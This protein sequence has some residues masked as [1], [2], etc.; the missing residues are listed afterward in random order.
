MVKHIQPASDLRFK[1][2]Y[3]EPVRKADALNR[4]LRKQNDSHLASDR[5]GEIRDSRVAIR[6][7]FLRCRIL[8]RMRR[9]LR[10]ILRRPLPDFFVPTRKILYLI[11]RESKCQLAA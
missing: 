10:P 1:L 9:F 3:D 11:I 4:V 2:P 8:A 5:V 6:S 7:Y